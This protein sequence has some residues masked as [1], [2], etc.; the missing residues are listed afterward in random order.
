MPATLTLSTMPGSIEHNDGYSC[1][2]FD[3]FGGSL[4]RESVVIATV[5]DVCTAVRRFGDRMRADH[6]DTSFAI[7][8][9]FKN[10]DR[11]PR[12]FDDT[13]KNGGLGQHAFMHVVD[14]QT[15]A[16]TPG[17]VAPAGDA[18]AAIPLAG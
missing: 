11:K 14:K 17:A 3:L 1:H 7:S 15:P 6:P 4:G 10:G 5:V 2:K 18:P 12:D 13:R 9:T 8:V 16:A